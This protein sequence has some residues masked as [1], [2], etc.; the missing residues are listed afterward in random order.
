M[1]L[2][3]SF[4]AALW[5]AMILNPTENF[6][7]QEGFK[8]ASQN[9]QIVCKLLADLELI[10]NAENFAY[11][12][13]EFSYEL[14]IKE[15]QANF[16]YFKNVPLTKN[17]HP[18]YTNLWPKNFDIY[19]TLRLIYQHQKHL[20]DRYEWEWDRQDQLGEAIKD[21]KKCHEIW[22]NIHILNSNYGP[23]WKRTAYKELQES[24]GD[25]F[26]AEELPDMIPRWT[27]TCTK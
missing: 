25:K 15:I 17:F 22:Y 11:S 12:L 20:E 26:G 10:D 4:K 6:T 2:P 7:Y 27:L 8:F 16:Q 24:L 19:H 9:S 3:I 13:Q 5:L 1:S 23:M 21:T 14:G 18:R